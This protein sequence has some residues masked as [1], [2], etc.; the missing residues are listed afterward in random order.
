M[1][2]LFRSLVLVLLLST[3]GWAAT[4]TLNVTAGANATSHTINKQTNGGTF[5]S[6]V[7]LPM[8]TLQYVDSVVTVGSTY[9]YT[10]TTNS[11]VD[12]SAASAPCC[13]ALLPAGA[14]TVSCTV[15]T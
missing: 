14:S 8:P 2:V 6:L 15:N 3:P 11:S 4:V 13:V 10:S 12:S 9:C 5:S 1:R 7:T